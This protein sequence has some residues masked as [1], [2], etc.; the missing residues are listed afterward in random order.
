MFYNIDQINAEYNI[1]SFLNI[2]LII[3]DRNDRHGHSGHSNYPIVYSGKN[4]K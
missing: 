3:F 2:I 1:S 4:D